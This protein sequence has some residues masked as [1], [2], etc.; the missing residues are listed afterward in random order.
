[1]KIT[2]NELRN[3]IKEEIEMQWP[4]SFEDYNN[5]TLSF[6]NRDD[7]NKA[8]EIS[9][10]FMPEI[11]HSDMFIQFDN[12]QDTNEVANKCKKLGLKFEII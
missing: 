4:D 11:G 3:I 9:K 2:T 1:M 7:F 6:L 8:L 10:Q 12:T 5:V